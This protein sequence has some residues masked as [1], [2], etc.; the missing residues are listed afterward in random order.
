[1]AM[2][3]LGVK[4]FAYLFLV[5]G[6][7]AGGEARTV[8][9][10]VVGFTVN[11]AFTTAKEKGYYKEEGLEVQFIL[12]NAVVASR[13]LIPRVALFVVCGSA[14]LA[15]SQPAW[16]GEWDRVLPLGGMRSL[17][18]VTL[19]GQSCLSYDKMLKHPCS[20]FNSTVI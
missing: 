5:F 11:T 4:F 7:V 16:Q 12:M 15:L 1:M 13:A 17:R 2:R 8:N 10:A 20:G 19:F 3:L 18:T 14:S 6:F 9:V